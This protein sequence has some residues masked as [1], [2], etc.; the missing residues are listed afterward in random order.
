MEG[1]AAP[2][3]LKY[4]DVEDK[5]YDVEG[6]TYPLYLT[7]KFYPIGWSKD[8]KFAYITEPADEAVGAYFFEFSIIDLNSSE[9]VFS[10]KPEENPETGSLQQ[11]W[12]ENHTM[13]EE[14]LRQ[15]GIVQQEKFALEALELEGSDKDPEIWMDTTMAF[16]SFI[17]SSCVQKVRVIKG[18]DQDS[19]LLFEKTYGEYDLVLDENLA[20]TL[21]SP[22]ENIQA[23]MILYVSRG[24]EGPPHVYHFVLAGTR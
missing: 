14:V 3:E 6:H 23:T 17:C 1:Y 21:R 16:N 24:Y 22:Y 11:T 13:F 4:V 19:K 7:D 9:T 18:F 8:G 15:H 20:G 5:T 2:L 12:D 10:W